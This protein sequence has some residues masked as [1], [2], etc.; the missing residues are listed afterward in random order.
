MCLM[1]KNLHRI[2]HKFY[3][4]IPININNAGVK[5]WQTIL[6]DK[7]EAGNHEEFTLFNSDHLCCGLAARCICVDSWRLDPYSHRPC[8]HFTFTCDHSQGITTNN[9]LIYTVHS[10]SKA[11]VLYC[12]QFFLPPVPLKGELRSVRSFIFA[13]NLST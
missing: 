2:L 5:S 10:I 4:I 13:E 1:G 3:P 8:D 7:M 6:V 11:T 12:S 9:F